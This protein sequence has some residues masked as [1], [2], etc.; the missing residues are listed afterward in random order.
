MARPSGEKTRCMGMWTEAKFR[1]FIKN[2][3]RSATRK[4][5][6]IQRCKNN[7][8]VARGLY[9][10]ACCEQDVSNTT[11]DEVS[12]A[13]VNNLFI[14]HINPIVD[15]EVGFQGWDVLIDRMFCELDNLQLLCKKCH[16]DKTNKE[17]AIAK[18][19][20]AKAKLDDEDL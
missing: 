15:P 1:S 6:P 18:D 16:D 4:W 20:R 19:R 17:K 8:R 12:G 7:A 13:R 11:I 2:N 3:L 5:A 10:C 9:R 14:D